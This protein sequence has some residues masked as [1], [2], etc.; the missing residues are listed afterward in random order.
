MRVARYNQAARKQTVSLTINADLYAKAKS[1]GVNASQVAEEALAAA[2][3]RHEAEKIKAEI[4][5]D[6]EACNE[7]VAKHGSPAELTRAHYAERDDAV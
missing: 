5:Q 7:Y 3:A 2:L 6:L 4:R 1:A